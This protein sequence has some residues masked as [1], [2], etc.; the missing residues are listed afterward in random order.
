VGLE[1]ARAVASA[2]EAELRSSV[3]A[4]ESFAA[5]LALDGSDPTVFYERARRVLATRSRWAAMVLADPSGTRV[6]DTRYRHDATLPPIVD[7]DSF[8][9]AVRNRAP[10]IGNLARSPQG[11]ETR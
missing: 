8:D 10:A 6:A 3:S 11:A 2:V 7:R 4:L 9:R 1:L 5:T